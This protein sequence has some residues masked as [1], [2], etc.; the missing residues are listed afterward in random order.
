MNINTVCVGSGPRIKPTLFQDAG[1]RSHPEL[2]DV[3]PNEMCTRTSFLLIFALLYVLFSV[4]LFHVA[5]VVAE[6]SDKSFE[7]SRIFSLWLWH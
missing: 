5:D 1:L 4:L 7:L 6:L 2:R 3:K